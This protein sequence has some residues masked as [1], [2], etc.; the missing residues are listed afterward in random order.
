MQQHA[1][2]TNGRAPAGIM[3]AK[4]F[5]VVELTSFLQLSSNNLVES[6]GE[7]ILAAARVDV[8]KARFRERSLM[9]LLLLLLLPPPPSP[10][11]EDD[12]VE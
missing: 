6:K 5:L 11:E 2:D 7:N 1:A 10:P 3:A 9:L 4:I 8:S 12:C